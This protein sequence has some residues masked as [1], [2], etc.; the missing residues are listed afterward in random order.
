[1]ASLIRDLWKRCNLTL[2]SINNLDEHHKW[3][4]E[5]CIEGSSLGFPWNFGILNDNFE[6]IFRQDGS[7]E[8]GSFVN[9]DKSDKSNIVRKG[10]DTNEY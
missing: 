5:M 10:N 2:S 3:Y 9:C 6:G 8:I 1:V 4:V 7:W